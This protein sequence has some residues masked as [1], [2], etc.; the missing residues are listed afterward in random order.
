MSYD[1]MNKGQLIG[2]PNVGYA[3]KGMAV[4]VPRM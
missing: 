3:E 4:E 1:L 2:G